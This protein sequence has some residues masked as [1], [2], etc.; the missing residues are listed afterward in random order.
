MTPL[1]LYLHL[2]F[3]TKKC[4]YCDFYSFQ[5]DGSVIK[6]NVKALAMEIDSYR[7]Y[8][9]VKEA[10]VTT[11]FFGGGTPTVLSAEALGELCSLV[12]S[13]FSLAPDVEWTVECNPDSF[14][15]EKAAVIRESGVTRLTFGI[16]SLDDRELSLL[17]RVHSAE[18]CLEVLRDPVLSRFKSIGVD[19]MYGLPG[20]TVDSLDYTLNQLLDIP[21]ITHVSAYELTI[22]DGTPFGRHR[23]LLPLPDDEYMTKITGQMWNRLAGA[24]FQQY[25]VSNFAKPGYRC[26]HNEA[27][28]DHAAY[29]GIGC[30]AHSYLHPQRWGN[31]KDISHYF[32]MVE[33]GAF[34]REFTEILDPHKLAT[35]I[36][37]L[38]LRRTKGINEMTFMEKCGLIL[39]N[40]IDKQKLEYYEQ[41]GLIRYEKPFW[42]PTA[43][44]MLVADAMARELVSGS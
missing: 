29:L 17:G 27:Y 14:T 9:E 28:W 2:P 7:D 8:P 4:R 16:Q 34:P 15:S 36:V 12:R 40:F 42:R 26:R 5:T 38:G 10:K 6:R 35:E 21:S 20:Q 18:R 41:Q 32:A 11:V 44:G 31:V 13:R 25:E 19:V 33:K 23:S 3:C 22:A 39:H 30:A 1:S 43:K 24:G 37:F